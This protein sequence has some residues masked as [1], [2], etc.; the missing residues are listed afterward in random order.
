MIDEAEVR[1]WARKRHEENQ[2]KTVREEDLTAYREM[3]LKI[4]LLHDQIQDFQDRRRELEI[5]IM[6]QV[7]GETPDILVESTE[8]GDDFAQKV[9]TENFYVELQLGAIRD[10]DRCLLYC[11]KRPEKPQKPSEEPKDDT[12]PLK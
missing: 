4:L 3:D 5:T 1:A 9:E 8:T 10:D 7:A 11:E 12:I 2:G 6:D